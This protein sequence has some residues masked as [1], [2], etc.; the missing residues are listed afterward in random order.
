MYALDDFVSYTSDG[1]ARRPFITRNGVA[2]GPVIVP[3]CMIYTKQTFRKPRPRAACAPTTLLWR[4]QSSS[5]YV[6]RSHG[7]PQKFFQGR[8]KS[9]FCI[10]LGCWRCNAY[11]RTQNSSLFLHHKEMPNVTATIAYSV[12]PTR[13][14]YT[15]LKFVLVSMDILRLS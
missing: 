7:R 8:A 2:Q 5:P 12:F 13:K 9:K 1:Q 14:L 6:Y 3:F 10:S 15:K 4:S 11:G